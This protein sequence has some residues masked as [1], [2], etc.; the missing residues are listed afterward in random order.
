MQE[1]TLPTQKAA[2][3]LAL[4]VS[5]VWFV[6]VNQPLITFFAEWDGITMAQYLHT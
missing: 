3:S 5:P 1:I 6:T 2:S 4:T